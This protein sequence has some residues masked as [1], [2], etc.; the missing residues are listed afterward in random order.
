[1]LP[2]F[3]E[4]VKKNRLF[5]RKSQ[6]LLALSGGE[7]SICLFHLLKDGGYNFSIA[8][9][10]FALRGK[11]SD[12]DEIFVK[13]LADK[14]GI[15][16]HLIRF[17]TKSESKRL[18]M[19]TQETARFLRYNWFEKLQ[20]NFN[21]QLVLTA[22]HMDDN[23]ETML[24]NLMRGT[25]I[26]GLHGIPLKTNSICRPLLFAQKKLISE[27]VLS[28]G[29]KFRADSSNLKDDYLRNQLRHH[30]VPKLQK[31]E[32]KVN[33]SFSSTA[34]H[35]KEYESLAKSLIIEKWSQLVK[36]IDN[37][38]FFLPFDNLKLIDANLL[39][40]FLFENLKAFG[41]NK[42]QTNK[43]RNSEK[44]KT[45]FKLVSQ[46]HEII[47]EREGLL[48]CPIR[49]LNHLDQIITKFPFYGN[50]NDFSVKIEQISALNIELKNSE[51]LYIDA[52]NIKMPIRIRNWKSA[53]KMQPLGM[54]G[55]K[56]ISDIL[57]DNKIPNAIRKSVLVVV[58]S[59]EELIALLPKMPSD[60]YKVRHSSIVILRF[61]YEKSKFVK[62][63]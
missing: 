58:D 16:I 43:L 21:Y 39:D 4:F 2:Y 10:N 32:P 13:K 19:N 6:L 52:S 54:K 22:H 1:M 26:A 8:H 53:D 11:E 28:N 46:T 24:I 7:D 12:Q 33:L 30:I 40:V 35:L 38:A 57:T 20:E 48:I 3:E 62:H 15:S 34:S 14:H 36:S 27:Y 41:F 63:L 56:K 18:G 55:R 51:F 5:T 23:T 31:I 25:G 17:D 45:G 61:S 29:Y 44:A 9:C 60:V 47:K 49:Q 59:N 50:F 37:N 42:D